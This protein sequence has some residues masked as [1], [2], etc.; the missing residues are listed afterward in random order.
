MTLFYEELLCSASIPWVEIYNSRN[1]NS[2]HRKNLQ[3]HLTSQKDSENKPRS[4]NFL[5]QIA[6]FYC[7][8]QKLKSARKRA[9]FYSFRSLSNIENNIKSSKFENVIILHHRECNFPTMER[10]NSTWSHKKLLRQL[11][12]VSRGWIGD[13]GIAK[14]LVIIKKVYHSRLFIVLIYNRGRKIDID[15]FKSSTLKISKTILITQKN[16]RPSSII[17]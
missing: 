10:F 3:F 7:F 14:K 9:E 1:A 6:F 16:Y 13:W 2:W 11:L 15:F 8:I 17:Q 4:N 12:R 5:C